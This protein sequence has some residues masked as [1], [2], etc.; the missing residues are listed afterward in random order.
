MMIMELLLMGPERF[1]ETGMRW[2]RERP[3]EV[4]MEHSMGTAS[5]DP[6][7]PRIASYGM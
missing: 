6:S 4:R 2:R 1:L 7:K 3:R 5:F